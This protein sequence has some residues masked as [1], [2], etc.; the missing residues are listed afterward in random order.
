MFGGSFSFI[1]YLFGNKTIDLDGGLGIGTP[2]WSLY[3]PPL[4]MSLI[5][6]IAILF[7]IYNFLQDKRKAWLFLLALCIGMISMF[8]VYAGIIMFGAFIVFALQQLRSKNYK[9]FLSLILAALV[10]LGTYWL[11]AGGSGSLI[12]F[13]LWGPERLLQSF[14][15]F[16]YDNKIYVYT[17]YVVSH[18]HFF[19]GLIGL[20]YTYT[21]GLVLFIFGSLGTRLLGFL[22]LVFLL[23]PKKRKLP[24][25]FSFLL[26]VMLLISIV[27]PLFFI[28][29]GKVFE[30]IQMG[31]YY[32]FFC[33]LFAGLGFATFFALKFN[34]YIKG[35][36]LGILLISTV[37][38][39]YGTFSSYL[40][41]VQAFRSMNSPYFQTMH[42]LSTIGKYDDT[43]LE[44]PPNDVLPTAKSIREWYYYSSN[45]SLTALANKRT[46]FDNEFIDFPNLDLRERLNYMEDV[47][48]LIAN[49]IT[50]S[51][52]PN[53]DN[54]LLGLLKDGKIKYI[55]VPYESPFLNKSRNLKRIYQKGN[56]I[57]YVV[58]GR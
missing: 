14:T 32:L 12:F 46:Y 17:N 15:W 30:I 52:Y 50:S 2:I 29:T 13:P 41:E 6:I 35:L 45:A 47:M 31:Q 37:P 34:K 20:A 11:F 23:T 44:L 25:F 9:I 10:F 40:Q 54:Q 43:V 21:T 56:Y 1:F 22:C 18:S 57:L 19:H 7:M 28:Q 8:K 53:M 55:Y 16:N 5:I 36:I 51:S 58:N 24:S 38:H 4:S 27:I 33:S 39:M 42:Y 49:D 3:N 26:F 48:Q